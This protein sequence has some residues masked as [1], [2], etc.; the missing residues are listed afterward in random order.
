MPKPRARQAKQA[1]A[2]PFRAV[3]FWL[4]LTAAGVFAAFL[5]GEARLSETKPAIGEWAPAAGALFALPLLWFVA[6]R[7]ISDPFRRRLAV[8]VALVCVQGLAGWWMAPSAFVHRAE[9]AQGRLALQLLLA[10]LTF[11]VTIWTAVGLAPNY[12]D[13]LG[14]DAR[15]FR[16]EAGAL[17][18]LILAQIGLGGLVSGL[19]AGFTYN[20]WPLM[21]GRFIPPRA[22]LFFQTP[23]AANFVDNIAMV[24]LQHR[25]AAYVALA[26]SLFHAFHIDREKVAKR[27]VLRA[28]LLAVLV[29]TQTVLG[30]IAVLLVAPLPVA[31]AHKAFALMVLAM[32]TIHLRK[33]G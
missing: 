20:T 8:I 4:W 18:T 19:D 7:E 26:L 22:D 16:F 27:A 24:Q 5:G 30:V 15:A 9:A 1:P 14:P 33:L 10:A 13:P 3:R 31:L 12:R 17:L 29:A 2:D 11:S 21:D 25:L 32:A 23:W 28:R 6:R